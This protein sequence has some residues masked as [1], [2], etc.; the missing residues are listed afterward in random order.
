[1]VKIHCHRPLHCT[2][3]AHSNLGI[4]HSHWCAYCILSTSKK[5]TPTL[6]ER[7]AEA[8]VGPVIVGSHRYHCEANLGEDLQNLEKYLPD[9][10][11][12]DVR[13]W[14]QGDEVFV[15]NVM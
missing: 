1:M 6:A 11:G 3:T 10:L 7:L 13:Y 8:L 15:P 4:I 2:W 5:L 9:V 12:R 14:R